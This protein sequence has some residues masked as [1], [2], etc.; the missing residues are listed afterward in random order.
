MK[1]TLLVII[2]FIATTFIYAQ[3]G[4]IDVKLLTP[5]IMEKL[6]P[7]LSLTPDQ[8]VNVNEAIAVFLSKKAEILA[9][10]KS[11]PAGYTSKFNLLN[12]DLINKLKDIVSAKQM[13]NF[14]SLRPKV[15]TSSNVLSQL[16]F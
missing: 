15:N 9:L 8:K 14:L 7:A 12:G 6:T 16:F 2:A 11:D 5:Q 3:S 10:Q 13:G 1:K 4:G